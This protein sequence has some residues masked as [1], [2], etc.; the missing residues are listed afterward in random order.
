MR[1]NNRIAFLDVAKAIGIYLVI[2]G[3]MVVFNYKTFRFIYAFHMPLFF[4]ISGIILSNKELPTIGFFLKKISKHYI[5]PFLFALL[6]SI[7][8][9][10]IIPTKEYNIERLFTIDTIKYIYEG[11]FLF[12]YFESAWFLICMFWAQLFFYVLLALKSKCKT[13]LYI[14]IW[15]IWIILST[16]MHDIV[17]HIPFFERLPMKIDSAFMGTVF[18]GIGY[19]LG[20][21]YV[22][23]NSKKI[24]SKT[25]LFIGAMI[26]VV[27]GFWGVF[28][29]SYKGNTYVN[30]LH[31]TYAIEWRFYLG[32]ILGCMM[33][34]GIAYLLR[35]IKVL[36]LIGNI[37][38]IILLIHKPIYTLLR[39]YSSKLFYA[40][41]QYTRKD[42][43]ALQCGIISVLTL[44][45]CFGIALAYNR[46][47]VLCRSLQDKKAA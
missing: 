3:H 7:L 32:S 9:C 38:L 25:I 30:I 13:Y 16:Y 42:V 31:L 26:V 35:K 6:L 44:F 15:M 27:L 12:S 43:F 33:V 20:K 1:I 41:E 5:L 46:I 18:L 10:V 37:T 23:I 17:S 36:Q 29:V 24:L 40:G 47:S 19:V 21:I 14:L 45:I 4:V 11:F 34:L 22:L 8:Q 28:F 39:Y 2:L